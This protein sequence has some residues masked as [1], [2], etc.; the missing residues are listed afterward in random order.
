MELLIGLILILSVG[1][2]YSA[3]VDI[4]KKIKNK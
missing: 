1:L 3:A 4:I 2:L